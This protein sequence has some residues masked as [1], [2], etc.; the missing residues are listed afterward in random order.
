MD[1]SVYQSKKRDKWDNVA[2]VNL[3]KVSR[4]YYKREWERAKRGL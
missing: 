4:D 1:R 2:L 3:T